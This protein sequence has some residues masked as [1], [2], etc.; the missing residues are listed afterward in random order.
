[1]NKNSIPKKNDRKYI[2]EICESLSA[3]GL[4]GNTVVL[5]VFRNIWTYEEFREFRSSYLTIMQ[6]N[7]IFAIIYI[8]CGGILL[9][10]GINK[11]VNY[12]NIKKRKSLYIFIILLALMVAAGFIILNEVLIN[13]FGDNFLI[14]EFFI[15]AQLW[16]YWE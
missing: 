3:I 7:P 5:I 15:V 4:F 8:L 13:K 14:C 2:T 12:V 10:C 16:L 11:L 9:L 6:Y 1:M